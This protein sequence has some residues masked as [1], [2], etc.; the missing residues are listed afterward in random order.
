MI[1]LAGGTI[2]KSSAAFVLKGRYA[3]IRGAAMD[4]SVIV[5]A[6]VAVAGAAYL[7]SVVGGAV[8]AAR[9]RRRRIKRRMANYFSN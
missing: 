7:G 3:Q 2:A 4:V 9:K 1:P 8:A 5:A 6:A